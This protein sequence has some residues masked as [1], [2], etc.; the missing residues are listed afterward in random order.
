MAFAQGSGGEVY[1]T[2]LK[3]RISRRAPAPLD[4]CASDDQDT[5]FHFLTRLHH[6]TLSLP[7]IQGFF[8][9]M[10]TCL[11]PPPLPSFSLYHWTCTFRHSRLY[12]QAIWSPITSAN[13]PSLICLPPKPRIV[14]QKKHTQTGPSQA[15]LASV[16]FHYWCRLGRCQAYERLS[17][18]QH[19]LQSHT[20]LDIIFFSS[21]W[22]NAIKANVVDILIA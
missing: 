12:L 20:E 8:C 5:I 2:L 3:V 7:Q 16:D 15:P 17:K 13:S 9:S 4:S 6:P 1:K 19:K 22:Q 11:S 18:T 10:K 21:K 14:W